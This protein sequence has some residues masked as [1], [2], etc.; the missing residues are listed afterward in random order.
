MK[1]YVVTAQGEDCLIILGIYRTEE[2]AAERS[3][4]QEDKNDNMWPGVEEFELK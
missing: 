2:A 1:V 3:S 4:I